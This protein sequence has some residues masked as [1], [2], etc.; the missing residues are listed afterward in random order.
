[1]RNYMHNEIVKMSFE[2][3]LGIIEFAEILR[4]ERRYWIAGQE[5]W[6][7]GETSAHH[8][9]STSAHR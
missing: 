2:F 9:I 7:A 1:M 6:S 4:E 5:I 3:A 8:H